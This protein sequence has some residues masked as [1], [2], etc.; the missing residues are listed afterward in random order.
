MGRA[1]RDGLGTD[2]QIVPA[3][4][5]GEVTSARHSPYPSL[6]SGDAASKNLQTGRSEYQFTTDNRYLSF[7]LSAIRA[8]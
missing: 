8:Q 7:E 4:D 3:D 5:R 2:T 6:G 1:R